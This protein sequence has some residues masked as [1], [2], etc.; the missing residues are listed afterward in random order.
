[1]SQDLESQTGGIPLPRPTVVSQPFWDGCR[2]GELLFQRCAVCATA[3]FLPT[4]ACRNCLSSQLDWERSGGQGTVYS[5]TV[6]H[7][8]QTP[9]FSVPYAVAIIDIDEGYQMM[10]NLI[11]L[12][13]E[14][15]QVG[16]RV[17]VDFRELSDE[18][19]LPYF[20]PA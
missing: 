15:V 13:P 7:R 20:R 16:L 18:I 14:D 11:G 8:P 3:N 1:M 2:R 4:A 19:T 17:V 5:W 9:A 10:S 12:P 6:V